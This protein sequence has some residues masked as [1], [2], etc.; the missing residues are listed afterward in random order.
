MS[1]HQIDRVS[2]YLRHLQEHPAEVQTL[3]KELLIGVSSFFRDPEAF[4][5]LE[6][7]VIPA[8][9]EQRHAARNV[10]VWV[11]GCSTGEEA[12]SIAMLMREYMDKAQQEFNGQIFANVFLRDYI[13]R[14]SPG[15]GQVTGVLDLSQLHP[16]R[17]WRTSEDVL[18]G[19]A[20]DAESDRL[21]V[22]GKN[23]P[24]LFEIRLLP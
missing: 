16:R 6:R 15:S 24:K 2:R 21:F 14:I 22:T 23:W 7:Q 4:G 13:V 12:Y 8:L 3:F 11:P 5:I 19:I 18:N 20:Y 10:R 1:V 9:F 17:N